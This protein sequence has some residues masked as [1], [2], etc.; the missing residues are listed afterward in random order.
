M[1]WVKHAIELRMER[2][3]SVCHPRYGSVVISPQT[4]REATIYIQI[5][6]AYVV[7]KLSYLPIVQFHRQSNLPEDTA[8]PPQGGEMG[9]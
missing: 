9:G 4:W 1:H 8:S 5:H 2:F 7:A 6:H 3:A